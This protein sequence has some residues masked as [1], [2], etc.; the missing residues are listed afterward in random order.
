MTYVLIVSFNTLPFLKMAVRSAQRHI[1]G[2]KEIWVWDNGSKDGSIEWASAYADIL[3]MGKNWRDGHGAALDKMVRCLKNGHPSQD[4]P[5]RV[6][7]MDSDVEITGPIDVE[8][9]LASRPPDTRCVY[10]CFCEAA[11]FHPDG[12][13]IAR[14]LDPALSLFPTPQCASSAS[15]IPDGAA[16]PLMDVGA[17]HYALG[18]CLKSDEL[19]NA[20]RHYGNSTW[21]QNGCAEDYVLKKIAENRAIVNQRMI[22]LGYEP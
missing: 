20:A 1:V 13:K 6:I 8:G 10:A 2:P 14:R 3:F 22:D 4:L 12:R 15:F 17:Y 9:I 19:L 7:T 5:I 11:E 18:N 21:P 16:D